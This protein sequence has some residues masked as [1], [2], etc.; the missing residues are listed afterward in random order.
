MSLKLGFNA[1]IYLGTAPRATWG[2]ADATGAHT[3]AAPTGL[4]EGSDVKDLSIPIE[5]TE[6]DVTTR[7]AGGWETVVGTLKKAAIDIPMIWDPGD[8][9][10]AALMKGFLTD[11]NVP[12]AMLDGDKVTTGSQGLWAD[13]QV[14]KADKGEQLADAQMITFS[15]KPGYS[16]VPPEWVKVGT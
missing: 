8:A 3:G 4:S 7:G 5:K 1:K 10:C 9:M 16:A 12:L 13:F 11:A 14:L 15:V 6:A 2:A